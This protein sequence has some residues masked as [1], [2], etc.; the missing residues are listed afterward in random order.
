MNLVW[1]VPEKEVLVTFNE[2]G[3]NVPRT[4]QAATQHSPVRPKSSE[5]IS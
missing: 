4:D 1:H 2:L 3:W 5:A